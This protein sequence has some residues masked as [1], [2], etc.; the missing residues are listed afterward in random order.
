[1]GA[2]HEEPFLQGSKIIDLIMGDD[3]A[4]DGS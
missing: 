1:M 3:A 4:K 2:E